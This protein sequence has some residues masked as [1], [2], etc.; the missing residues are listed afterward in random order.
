MSPLLLQP[1]TTAHWYE[2]IHDAEHYCH[3]CLTE[4][5]QSYLVF[6]LMRYTQSPHLVDRIMALEYLHSLQNTGRV[7]Q[8]KLQEVGDVCLLFS[9]LFP[10]QSQRRRVQTK[11]YVE[12]GKTAYHTLAD[13]IQGINAHLYKHLAHAFIHLMDVL[14]ATRAL[15]KHT[16]SLSI[17][18]AIELWQQTGSQYARKMVDA[19]FK[20]RPCQNIITV[21]RKNGYDSN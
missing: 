14:L 5:L 18:H 20:G 7:Q 15:F 10:E 3:Q 17:F 2:L 16:P 4:E 8:Q 11:Y 6:L 1:T 19:Y 9:G 21:E 12:L 13:Q